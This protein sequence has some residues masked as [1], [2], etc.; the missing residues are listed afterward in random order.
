MRLIALI[1]YPLFAS[2]SLNLHR[3]ILPRYKFVS[4]ERRGIRESK[5]RGAPCTDLSHGTVLRSEHHEIAVSHETSRLRHLWSRLSQ[6]F[7]QI[8]WCAECYEFRHG[9]R[10]LGRTHWGW[11]RDR[12]FSIRVTNAHIMKITLLQKQNC[13]ISISSV[14]FAR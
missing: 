1:N 6:R 3:L 14:R 2:L 12:K 7:N 10:V 13:T 4:E 11:T 5:T 8:L 9:F